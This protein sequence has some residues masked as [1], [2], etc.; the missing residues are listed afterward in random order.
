[1]EASWT[2]P[3]GAQAF[4]D[5]R[6]EVLQVLGEVFMLVPKQVD[7][8]GGLVDDRP[9]LLLGHAVQDPQHLDG[10]VVIGVHEIKEVLH[11]LPP[12]EHGHLPR[13]GLVVPQDD[14]EEHEEA[15]DGA[16]VLQADLHVQRYAGDGLAACPDGV[17]AP[18]RQHGPPERTVLFIVVV[19][20]SPDLLEQSF[21]PYS[22]EQQKTKICIQIKS[23]ICTI[24]S[25]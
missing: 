16:G 17:H 23:I 19:E 10:G 13:E 4:L 21:G 1:M 2:T 22:Y 24:D 8:Q 18:P 5:G 3:A 11:K 20:G 12:Q 6:H 7:L 25:R 9:I 14:I 15:I